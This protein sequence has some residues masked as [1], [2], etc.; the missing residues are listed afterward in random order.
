MA[1]PLW[2]IVAGTAVAG[3]A[4]YLAIKGKK[5]AVDLAERIIAEGRDLAFQWSLPSQAQPYSEVILSASR[6]KGVDPFLIAA[7]GYKESLWGQALTPPGPG[8]T[9]DFT[10]RNWTPTP[11]PPDGLGW[12]RGLMQLDYHWYRD[13]FAKGLNWADPF[14]NVVAGAERY[15]EA[16]TYFSSMP[17]TPG[18]T[19]SAYAAERR[20]VPPGVYPDPRPLAGS[21]LN[22]AAIAAYNTGISNVLMSLAAGVDPDVTT[23]GAPYG[24]HNYSARV[25]DTVSDY[26]GRFG[27]QV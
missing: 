11:M 15:L 5:G 10:P 24:T 14:Q 13:Q 18:V 7:I 6:L 26:V 1:P 16:V 23:A 12:G 8:G 25:L 21:L 17:K 19:L 9:G 20:G 4:L 22:R 27:A 2:K 3:G